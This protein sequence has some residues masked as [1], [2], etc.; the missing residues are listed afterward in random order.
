MLRRVLTGV[1]VFVLACGLISLPASGKQ[2]MVVTKGNPPQTFI[3]EIDETTSPG[4]VLIASATQG[5]IE[6]YRQNVDRVTYFNTPADEF[7]GRLSALDRKDVSARI[8]LANFAFTNKMYPQAR[9]LLVT[10]LV[11]EPSNAN[12]AELL[13]QVDE[14]IKGAR[15]PETQAVAPAAEVNQPPARSGQARARRTL[16]PDEINFIRQ[17]EWTENDQNIRV[18]VTPEARRGAISLG[19]ID[20][21][22]I[23]NMTPADI[24]WEIVRHGPPGLRKD[25]KIGSDPGILAS[26]RTEVH[27]IAIASCATGACHNTDKGGNF[28]LF[29][30]PQTSDATV[31][32]DYLILQQYTKT[33]KG[34]EY[35]MIDALHPENSLLIQFA[36]PPGIANVPHPKAAGYVAP[37]KPPFQLKKIQDWIGALPPLAPTFDIDL[38]KPP[39][40]AEGAK[41]ATRP[42]GAGRGA[43]GAG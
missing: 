43:V 4:K 22:A 16:T 12:A 36:V 18:Q 10:A 26:Y 14:Q 33:I 3:G 38:S 29:T 2:G 30:E 27:R 9:E 31:V 1:G 19:L 32:T 37:A 34:I 40:A 13:R 7:A 20:P 6:V 42:T 5:K 23:G 41:P 15:P 39:P 25:V 8:E 17:T 35:Q 11:I 21:S 28:Y 24:G